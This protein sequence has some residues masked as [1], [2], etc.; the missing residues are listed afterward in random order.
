MTTRRDLLHRAA[1]LAELER[2]KRD[3]PLFWFE[4]NRKLRSFHTDP[5]RIRMLVAANRTGKTEHEIAEAA[6]TSLGFRPWELRLAGAPC[7]PDPW[8]MPLD[9]PEAAI[10]KDAAGVRVKVPNEILI[11]C[12][13]AAK[14]GIRE[15]IHPKLMTYLGP[16]VQDVYYES[17]HTPGMVILKNGSKVVYAGAKKQGLAFESTNYTA[18]FVDEPIPKRVYSGIRRGAIDQAA[19]IVFSFTPIGND[20]G[21]MFRDLYLRR[22]TPDIR[23]WTLTIFDNP[24][25]PPEE[26][27]RFA[28]DPSI[29]DVEKEAR[30]YGRFIHMVDRIWPQFDENVHV[31]DD[32]RPPDG[33][34]IA[35]YADPH[36]VRPWAMAWL[37]VNPQGDLIWFKEWPERDFATLRR[38]GRSVEDYAQLI[39]QVERNQ[40]PTEGCRFLDPNYG[41]RT[42]LVRGVFIKSVQ[43]ELA[44]YG[45]YA[46]TTLND[47]LV[48]GENRVRSLLGY[49]ARGPLTSVN[50][51]RMYVA[52][53]CQNL[54]NA[55]LY[56]TAVS[57]DEIPD[58]QKRDPAWKDFADLW[59]YAAVSPLADSAAADVYYD[60]ETVLQSLGG[61]QA[62]PL[63]GS[64][65]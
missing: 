5:A 1:A 33:W 63:G 3:A 20:A 7:P 9:A 14:D 54:I 42:D 45:I 36:T 29:S 21:W 30:L 49:D 25:N 16:Y 19:R 65:V 59:R 37:T 22:N 6:A 17:G 13:G 26:I 31:I 46:D 18:Y 60:L 4:P 28:D 43:D 2:R 23:T 44:E 8:T 40:I 10:V 50:R 41:R 48:Y 52:R 53:S 58:E 15:T 34:P 38:D 27:Q 35:W 57:K 24:W 32:F 47:D 51:P 39:R 55:A 56:Y 62:E 11:V 64:Y 12:G 61:T